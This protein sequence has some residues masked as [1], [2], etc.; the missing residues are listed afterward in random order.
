[1]RVKF[2]M[3][4]F[5]TKKEIKNSFQIFKE[6]VEKLSK[7]TQSNTDKI[8]NSLSKKEVE[9]MIKE[10]VLNLKSELLSEMNHE[11]NYEPNQRETQFNRVILKKMNK[12]R[13]VL[14]KTAIKGLVENGNNNTTEIMNIIVDER[15]L[16]GK[17]QF[18]HYLSLVRNELRTPLQTELRTEVNTEE[19]KKK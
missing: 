16:C 14:I 9:L 6:R 8:N 3:W 12:N 10:S 13:P 1:V 5:P 19:I 18:Y 15:G 7:Q 11:P 17:T 2:T 4:F